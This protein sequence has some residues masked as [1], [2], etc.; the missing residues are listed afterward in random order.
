[1]D[2]FGINTHMFTPNTRTRTLPLPHTLTHTTQELGTYEIKV[3]LPSGDE[4]PVKLYI[5]KR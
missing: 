5:V 4:L 2:T 1:M 3:R